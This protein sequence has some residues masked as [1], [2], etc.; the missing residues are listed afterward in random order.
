[1][2]TLTID[3]RKIEVPDPTQVIEAAERL[4]IMIPRFCYHPALGAVGA[5]RMCAVMFLEGPVKG[6]QMSCM[7]RAMDGMV[8][9][10]N[11]PEAVDFRRHVVEW[12]M[13][14]HPHD[15]PVCD[16]G[17]HCLLQDET[18]SGG[19]GR[20]IFHGPKRTYRDQDLGPLVRQEMNRCIHCYRCARFYQEYAG[21][22]DFGALGIGAR[23]YFGRFADGGLESPF[24]G[25]LIDLCPTGVLTDKPSRYKARHWD[26]ERAPS[27][28]LHCSL[29]CNINANGR[30]REL[31]RLEGRENSRVN[32]HFLCDRGRYGFGYNNSG[33]RPRLAEVDG[34]TVSH[35]EGVTLAAERLQTIISGNGDRAVALLGTDRTS[36]ECQLLLARLSRELHWR[37]PDFFADTGRG[38]ALQAVV[39]HLDRG[40]AA[41]P[42]DLELADLLI[43]VGLDPI[44]EAPMLAL[45]LRQAV[46]HGA[47]LVAL[48]PRPLRLPCEFEQLAAGPEQLPS[49]AAHLVKKGLTG[50]AGKEPSPELAAFLGSLPEAPAEPALAAS[51]DRFAGLLTESSQPALLCGSRLGP[52]ALPGL[53]LDLAR[54]IEALKGNCRFFLDSGGPNSL[55]AALLGRPEGNFAETLTAIEAGEVKGLVVVEADPFH[56]YPDRAR[57]KRVLPG[58]EFL[59]VLDYLPGPI[60]RQAQI[61]LPTATVFEAGG[62]FINQAGLLQYAAPVYQAG[63]P[64]HR[65]SQ[66]SHPPRHFGNEIPLGETRSAFATLLA[67]GSR[68]GIDLRT[69]VADPWSLLP[70][71]FPGAA[72]LRRLGYPAD[73][74]TLLPERA[75]LPA[76]TSR[77]LPTPANGSGGRL[78][79]LPVEAIFGTEEL[80][81]LG[82]VVRGLAPD[83]WAWMHPDDAAPAGIT[84]RC[85]VRL[86]LEE[87]E[88]ELEILLAR[89]MAPGYLILPRHFQLRERITSW[90]L[91]LRV[92]DLKVSAE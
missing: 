23:L 36:L 4:G 67:L 83:P 46:R 6:L 82:E 12:L 76:F 60:Y 55:A 38:Q 37:E 34:R 73:G 86:E 75:A 54:A 16:E 59:L 28:C 20:R 25:N 9:S 29:G 71:D 80:S 40:L 19:H 72:E 17:G 64:L 87:G 58:L 70:G 10:T 21:Y 48:D 14:N 50:V 90:P 69:A 43:V 88:I 8:V 47:R 1:M 44:N 26:L 68:L 30:Y 27:L 61:R 18:V 15:C 62:S 32:G 24:S 74:I 33:E 11:H 35:E 31:I 84:D 53:V 2:P 79:V 39:P 57:L 91:H 42:A 41:S 51:L 77:P 85:R 3:N 45:A 7:T 5:C 89:D 52:A 13:L 65:I 22:R 92:T 81:S 63:M 49:L 66:E 56:D 78:T